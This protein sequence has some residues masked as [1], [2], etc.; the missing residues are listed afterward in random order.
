MRTTVKPAPTWS[1][2]PHGCHYAYQD[3]TWSCAIQT[4][5][6][7]AVFAIANDVRH[8]A[9]E[10]A[11]H[12]HAPCQGICLRH[13]RMRHKRTRHVSDHT[14]MDK[15]TTAVCEVQSASHWT[16]SPCHVHICAG[17]AH[18]LVPTII[19]IRHPLITID[20][21]EDV[22][23]CNEDALMKA[24]A[25]QPISAAVEANDHDF[26][27]YNQYWIVKN[28]WGPDWG[29][30]GY[31]LDPMGLCG[32]NIQASYPVKNSNNAPTYLNTLIFL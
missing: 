28:S 20:G 4:R 2:A 29:E 3:A 5:V 15:N 10:L 31:I 19:Q 17:A 7:L 11:P 18:P 12:R 25:N 22:P 9:K 30:D 21:F 23:E 14:L 24:V 13:P 27:F 1:R 8:A 6:P 32:I 16:Y 26:Q